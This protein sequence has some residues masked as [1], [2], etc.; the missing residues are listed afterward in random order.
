MSLVNFMK[1]ILLQQVPK[2]G[3]PGDVQDVSEGYFRNFLLPKK[4]AEIATPVRVAQIKKIMEEK[5]K[6]AE[7]EKEQAK[8]WAEE[9]NNAVITFSAE[10]DE[11]GTLYAALSHH[12]IASRLKEKGVLIDEK[13]IQCKEPIKTLGEHIIFLKFGHGIEA[14]LKVEVSKK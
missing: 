9:L 10:A 4:L 11:K 14:A 12:S 5:K 3:N 13:H 8:R 2:L 6:Q 1:V 7:T